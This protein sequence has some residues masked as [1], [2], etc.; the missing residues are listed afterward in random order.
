MLPEYKSLKG[1]N[2]RCAVPG[3]VSIIAAFWSKQEHWHCLMKHWST[4]LC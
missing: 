3:M 1:L 2:R 4:A